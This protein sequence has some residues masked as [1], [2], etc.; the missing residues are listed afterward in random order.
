MILHGGVSG[1]QSHVVH[2][3]G[4]SAHGG[5][6]HGLL[7]DHTARSDSGGVFTGTA[8]LAGVNQNLN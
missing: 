2:G 3:L 6:V 7:L 1:A 4:D 8:V 5:H